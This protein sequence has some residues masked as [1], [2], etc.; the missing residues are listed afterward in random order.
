MLKWPHATPL[1]P[2]NELTPW[3]RWRRCQSPPSSSLTLGQIKSNSTARPE[4][5]NFVSCTNI[6]CQAGRLLGTNYFIQQVKQ[7]IWYLNSKERHPRVMEHMPLGF[8]NEQRKREL[9]NLQLKAFICV[10]FKMEFKASVHPSSRKPSLFRPSLWTFSP[11][12]A[13]WPGG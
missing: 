9:L 3:R 1:H 10:S 5:I 13:M 6:F 12:K 7:M 4:G 2:R 8:A 11:Q